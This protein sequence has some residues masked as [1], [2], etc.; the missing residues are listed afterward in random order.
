MQNFYPSDIMELTKKI[1]FFTIGGDICLPNCSITLEPKT[2]ICAIE[3]EKNI[4]RYIWQYEEKN[5]YVDLTD[6]INPETDL[7]PSSCK[8]ID[9]NIKNYINSKLLG[10]QLTF[11]ILE[12]E[13]DDTPLTIIEDLLYSKNNHSLD[14]DTCLINLSRKESSILEYFCYSPHK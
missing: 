2:P 13:C 1:R 12:D 11:L 3:I 6:H 7:Q 8:P 5:G 14:F 4:F 10:D 9:T